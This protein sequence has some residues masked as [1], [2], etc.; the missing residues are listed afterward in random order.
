MTH[1]IYRLEVRHDFFVMISGAA[2][3]LTGLVWVAMSLHLDLITKDVIHP[4]IHHTLG[5]M[6]YYDT[7][8][9]SQPGRTRGALAIALVRAWIARYQHGRERTALSRARSLLAPASHA[10][11]TMRNSCCFLLTNRL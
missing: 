11:A 10:K 6:V 8:T 7:E 5:L 2:A 3:V 9:A 4:G 1:D